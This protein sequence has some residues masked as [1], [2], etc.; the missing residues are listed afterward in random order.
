WNWKRG[1]T[2]G[3]K[4]GLRTGRDAW[5]HDDK[6]L[7][8]LWT[9]AGVGQAGL[10]ILLLEPT[11]VPMLAGYGVAGPVALPTLGYPSVGALFLGGM[12]ASGLTYAGGTALTGA[13]AVGGTAATLVAG[14]GGI[15]RTGV[16]AGLGVTATA[17]T[18]VGGTA[19]TV[20]LAGVNA[21]R[22]I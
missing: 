13:V 21:V 3:L 9:I 14:G 6:L 15:I 1:Y 20:G 11:V 12:T 4:E 22:T 8:T 18:A 5:N 2:Q 17:A 10:H 16:T 19:L 7:A